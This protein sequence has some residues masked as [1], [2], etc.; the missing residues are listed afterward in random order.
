MKKTIVLLAVAAVLMAL[1]P[2]AQAA[3]LLDFDFNSD[4]VGAAAPSGWFDNYSSQVADLSVAL[5]TN[6]WFGQGTGN[7]IVLYTET[8]DGDNGLGYTAFTP[9]VGNDYYTITFDYYMPTLAT[10]SGVV[11]TA[12]GNDDLNGSTWRNAEYGGP[13][14]GDL[15]TLVTVSMLINES[16]SAMDYYN[17]VTSATVSLADGAFISFDYNH[18]TGV[19]A[20]D[21]AG[22]SDLP[23]SSVDKF[24]FKTANSGI[25]VFY[26]DDVVLHDNQLFVVPEPATMS[27]LAIGGLG[28]L[29][30]RRRRRA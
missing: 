7:T 23:Y 18:S 20:V 26:F 14:G 5:D 12:L 6:D 13:D 4:T 17:P 10:A 11:T 8:N 27:L 19:Y 2:A 16:G 29:L 25:Q 28:L 24:G 30:K 21:G 22:T 9:D 15:D 3:T 1:A